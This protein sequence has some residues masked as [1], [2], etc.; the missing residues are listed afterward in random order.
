MKFTVHILVLALVLFPLTSFA[1]QEQSQ[2]DVASEAPTE[3]AETPQPEATSEAPV[4]T[5]D[6]PQPE[7]TSEA[8]VETVDTPPA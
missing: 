5:V 6:T 2:P 7:A 8:P 1:Q 3:T 4:E